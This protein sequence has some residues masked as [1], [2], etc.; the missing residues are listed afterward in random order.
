M[1]DIDKEKT[2]AAREK[3]QDLLNEV[4]DDSQLLDNPEAKAEL[5]EAKAFIEY[6][7]DYFDHLLKSLQS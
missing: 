7:R 3:L 1:I 6:A 4:N 5:E 2:E